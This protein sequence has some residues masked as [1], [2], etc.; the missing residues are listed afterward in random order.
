MGFNSAFK[1]LKGFSRSR[2]RRHGLDESLT[3]Q[4]QLADPGK[5]SNEH[6]VSIK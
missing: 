4:G 1:G 6:S 3:G 2:M 5:S